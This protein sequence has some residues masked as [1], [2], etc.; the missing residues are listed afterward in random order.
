MSTVLNIT[1]SILGQTWAWREG[2][3]DARDPG[4]RP[5]DQVTQLLMARGVPRDDIDRHRDPTIRAF[6]PD[7]SIFRDMDKGAERIAN[8]V[9]AGETVTVYG[10]YDVDGATSAALLDRKSVV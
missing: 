10:D 1:Q 7:P 8:A 2:N 6:M 9:E 5:D 4:F 3:V